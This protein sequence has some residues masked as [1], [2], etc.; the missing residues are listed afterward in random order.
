[1]YC[2]LT[3]IYIIQFPVISKESKMKALEIVWSIRL[4]KIDFKV[5]KTDNTH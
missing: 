2:F 4:K 3:K 1:M 5:N